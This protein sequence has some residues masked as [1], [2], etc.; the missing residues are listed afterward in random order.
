VHARYRG[1]R[2]TAAAT[3]GR[4]RTATTMMMTRGRQRRGS[5]R[6]P[7]VFVFNWLE[8]KLLFNPPFLNSY[9][10]FLRIFVFPPFWKNTPDHGVRRSVAATAHF[11]MEPC[12]NTLGASSL[13]ANEY[14]P[15]FLCPIS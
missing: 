8:I 1:R 3:D 12:P 10:E 14:C 15:C 13:G 9:V 6:R 11:K 2:M 4:W 7:F 5:A